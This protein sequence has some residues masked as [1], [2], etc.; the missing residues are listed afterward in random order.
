[1]S[2]SHEGAEVD[3][4]CIIQWSAT[5]LDYWWV[6]NNVCVPNDKLTV[7][8]FIKGSHSCFS[9]KKRYDDMSH[10]SVWHLPTKFPWWELEGWLQKVIGG[11]PPARLFSF[12]FSTTT[13]MHAYRIIL[14]FQLLLVTGKMRWNLFQNGTEVTINLYNNSSFE[15]S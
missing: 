15:G 4:Q 5:H 10:H 6:N 13:M 12:Y 1:M 9:K 2:N 7:F 8:S 11:A 3:I 14:F